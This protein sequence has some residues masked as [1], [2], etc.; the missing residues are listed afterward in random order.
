MTDLSDT[1][2]ELLKL[3]GGLIRYR[4]DLVRLVFGL[5]GFPEDQA[6]DAATPEAELRS[7]LECAL[8]DHLDPLLRT[9][10]ESVGGLRRT[11]LDSALDLVGFEHQI[12]SFCDALPRSPEEDAMLDG[13]IPADVPTEMRITINAIIGD[14]LKLALDNLLHAARYS[15]P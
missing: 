12:L 9:I 13:E 5:E 7:G 2:R 10:L 11:L 1:Q 8:V 14:Q 6:D 15:A 4:F 3:A